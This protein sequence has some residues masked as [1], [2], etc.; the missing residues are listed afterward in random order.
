MQISVRFGNYNPRRYSRPWGATVTFSGS[1]PVYDF[2]VANY[3]TDSSD[4]SAGELIITCQ[5]G[6]V[7]AVGQKDTRQPKNT[8]NTWY[9]VADDGN[10]NEI[11]RADAYRHWLAKNTP[12]NG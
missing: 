1:K 4:T 6:D 10:Y 11:T 2:G 12:S 8:E 9:L 7:V 5:P 3:L